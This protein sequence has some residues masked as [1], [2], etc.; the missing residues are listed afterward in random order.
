MGFCLYFSIP[1]LVQGL[2]CSSDG[3]ESVCNAGDPGLIPGWARSSGEGN[4]T[5]LQYSCLENPMDR[6][7]WRL[8][9]MGFQRVAHNW[10][11]STTTKLAQMEFWDRRRGRCACAQ[12]LSRVRLY[13]PMDRSL[14]GSSAHGIFPARILEWII[15][16]SSRVC[17][18]FIIKACIYF[19]NNFSSVVVIV[20]SPCLN[21][22]FPT[23]SSPLSLIKHDVWSSY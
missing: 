6:E 16:S 7:P 17:V 21:H 10:A 14:A 12:S 3:K 15:I 22:F 19:S 23:I 8:Q 11:T 20:F 2:P 18:Q 13:K 4:G 5:P 1:K 9:S